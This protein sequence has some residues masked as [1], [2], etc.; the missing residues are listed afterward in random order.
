MEGTKYDSGKPDYALLEPVMLDELVKVMTYGA[1]KYEPHNWK[2][3]ADAEDRYYAALMRHLNA[4]RSGEARDPE[5]GLYHLSHVL[6]NAAFLVWFATVGPQKRMAAADPPLH[7]SVP[8][9][10]GGFLPP[11]GFS[12]QHSDGA[13]SNGQ[14]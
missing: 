7:F 14:P 13:V 4:W 6:C 11:S 1:K 10:E 2:K 12:N 3:L 9:R 5:S 8:Y